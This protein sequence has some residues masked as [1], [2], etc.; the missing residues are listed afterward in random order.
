MIPLNVFHQMSSAQSAT[1]PMIGEE[2]DIRTGESD[3]TFIQRLN[4]ISALI[5]EGDVE[6]KQ[7]L[8]MFLRCPQPNSNRAHDR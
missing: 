2:S 1:A 4:F 8:S 7:S 3:P 6:P 5:R